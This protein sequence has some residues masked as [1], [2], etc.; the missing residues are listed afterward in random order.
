MPKSHIEKPYVK[1][2]GFPDYAIN[3]EDNKVYR[4]TPPCF[5]WIPHMAHDGTM[6]KDCWKEVKPF[7]VGPESSGQIMMMPRGGKR[8]LKRSIDNIVEQIEEYI[9]DADMGT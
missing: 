2:P 7:C 8:G 9:D 1:V 5:Q 6:P 4:V 3:T